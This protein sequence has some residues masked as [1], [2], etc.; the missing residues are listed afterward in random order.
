ME[1]GDG[2]ARRDLPGGLLE[3]SGERSGGARRLFDSDS[4]RP[5][6]SPLPTNL[7][8]RLRRWAGDF[9]TD[10][11][12]TPRIVLLVGGPGNGKT[13]AVEATIAWLDEFLG[14]Q[15]AVAA[16]LRQSF[17]NSGALRI[18]R[19]SFQD[20][21][22][23][24]RAV[25]V[26]QDASLPD[27]GPPKRTGFQAL[28]EDLNRLAEAGPRVA[29]LCCVNRGVLDDAFVHAIENGLE[30]PRQLLET[31]TRSVSLAP[32][33]PEC[34]PLD[35]YPEVAVWP[36]DSES[37]LV[38]TDDGAAAP[39][40]TLLARATDEGRWPPA[41]TC[42]AA[43]R[44]PFCAS[45]EL[46]S[47]SPHRD[48]LLKVLRSY[49]LASGKRWNFRDLFSMVS[50]SLTGSRTP[51][52][53]GHEGPCGWAAE[54]LELDAKCAGSR[55]ERHKSSAIYHLVTSAYQHLLFRHWD[56]AAAPTLHQD[57]KDLGLRDD[58]VLM[59]LYFFLRHPGAPGVTGSL[60]PLLGDL[61]RLLDPA[62]SD[63]DG[64]MELSGRTSRP[65]RDID[66]RFSQSVGAGL[67]FLKPYQCLA[68]LEVD[69]LGRLASADAMLGEEPRRRRPGAALRVQRLLR[70]FSCRLARRSIGMR[71]GAVRDAAV[72]AAF[73]QLVDTQHGSDDLMY[74]AASQVE[75]LLNKGEYFEVPLN[76]TF[77]QPLPPESR[78]A[79]LVVPKQR[80]REGSDNRPGRPR[81]PIP[82]LR[83]G[84][85]GNKEVPLTYELF[86]SVSE[87]NSGMSPSSLPKTVVALLDTT[88]ARLSGPIVRDEDVLD[89]AHFQVGN[90]PEQ[91]VR[92]RGRF[93]R[94][95]RAR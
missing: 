85:G 73:Q 92:A 81:S 51:V 17:A 53:A 49:E 45:R 90:S 33:A 24:P 44:C 67:A 16:M 19:A 4:G 55:P 76:T 79:T 23:H 48:S 2:L 13:E 25:E 29:Y 62:L 80:V 28:I 86:K 39:A 1:G 18:A 66:S 63:P 91:V 11:P 74:E 59:G 5:S 69:L 34:W 58:H 35:G 60:A 12:S 8:A 52:G 21:H 42:A 50:Y 94:R 54:Q 26:V 70:E 7:L 56:P 87:I 57:L 47:R 61:S 14:Q 72:L 6:G 40:A 71:S 37:L 3:W 78:R 32:G 83:I 41:G 31:I 84:P 9:A 88:R 95:E 43:I 15:G 36:M 46:L 77:G 64:Q 22:G 82:F 20:R 75:A 65:A 68:A 93:V 38:P 27:A 30:A 89:G 10:A